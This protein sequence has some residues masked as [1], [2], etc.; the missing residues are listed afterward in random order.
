MEPSLSSGDAC[1]HASAAATSTTTV[2]ESVSVV[3]VGN[4]PVDDRVDMVHS[5]DEEVE[6]DT[7]VAATGDGVVAFCTPLRGAVNVDFSAR[8]A[9][10]KLALAATGGV[11]MRPKN[12]LSNMSATMSNPGRGRRAFLLLPRGAMIDGDGGDNGKGGGV[13]RRC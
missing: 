7:G 13:A 3:G 11:C 1:V 6:R 10:V 2:G 8:N 5:V 12:V 9:S 4:D